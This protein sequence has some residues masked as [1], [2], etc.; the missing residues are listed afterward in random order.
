MTDVL[1]EY[2]PRPAFMPFH[3][4]SERWSSLVVHRRGGK[5]VACVHETIARASYTN[6]K[7]ARYAYIAPFYRQ[8]K[9]VAWGYLKEFGGDLIDK[10]RESE[11]RVELFN[12]A[13]ITLYG[14]DNPDALRGLY[15]DGVILDE[16]GDC[17]PSLWGTVVLPTLA[18][19]KGWAV[20]IGTPKGKNH[21]YEVHKRSKL[22]KNWYSMTLPASVSGIIDD[23]ELL[24]MKA[25][26]TDEAYNQELECDFEAAVQGTFYANQVQELELSG[27]IAP[28]AATH[29][30]R[31]KVYV[32]ADLGFSDSTAFWFWQQRADGFAVIDYYEAQGKKIPHYLAM[33][34]SRGY[35]YHT[36]Y[37]PHDAKAETLATDK[38]TVEQVINHFKGTDAVIDVVPK[39]KVQ[40]GIDAARFVLPQCYFNQIKCYE[41]I[42]AL[43]S[44]RRSYDEVKKCYSDKPWH[45]WASDGADAF[46]YFAVSCRADK[47]PDSLKKRQLTVKIEA[48]KYKLDE[49]WEDREGSSHKF[50]KLRM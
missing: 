31:K 13:W 42:E 11:L 47:R 25:Q 35:E 16:Y 36:I 48:P 44:Y 21:F 3:E 14:A 40:H 10:V 4:R 27:Q 12:G 15:F 33:L 19:R 28:D 24:E 8:A 9:D 6:K 2:E 30:P 43:R 50:S 34:D 45:D 39:L 5:T 18:D 1:I 23:E 32:A 17:R 37:L 7:N 20:F 22:E 29:D 38:S 26:M 49:L 41:G 46:R